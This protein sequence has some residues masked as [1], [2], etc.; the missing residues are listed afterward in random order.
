MER[1]QECTTRTLPPPTAVSPPELPEDLAQPD[2]RTSEPTEGFD[3]WLHAQL[4]RHTAGVSPAA[5]V[6]TGAGAESGTCR[7]PAKQIGAPA[8]AAIVTTQTCRE[9]SALRG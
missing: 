8:S 7:P 3:R 2:I 1:W 9:E 6:H 5:L 4:G